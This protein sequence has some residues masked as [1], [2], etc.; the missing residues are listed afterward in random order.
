MEITKSLSFGDACKKL[1][2]S[3]V[4]K[5][6]SPLG[7]G[8]DEADG[9]GK[10]VQ[11][12]KIRCESED[13]SLTRQ[14][15]ISSSCGKPCQLYHSVR[16]MFEE[17]FIRLAKAVERRRAVN[18][19]LAITSAS[20]AA[21]RDPLAFFTFIVYI[22]RFFNK[23]ELIGF[24]HYVLVA[25]RCEISELVFVKHVKVAR[26]DTAVRLKHKLNGTKAAHSAFLGM[27]AHKY[28]YIIFKSAII[29]IFARRHIRVPKIKEAAK[30]LA[31]AFGAEIFFLV[32]SEG[33]EA[34]NVLLPGQIILL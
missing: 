28:T 34:G 26:K 23:A 16:R 27:S 15:R 4:Y 6:A 25:V 2:L 18:E 17:H 14:G 11:T 10:N 13:L 31:V 30:K 8:G 3:D 5:K 29:Y 19:R 21:E 1:S 7:R 20:A 22:F 33:I 9:E 32:A 24:F 12:A